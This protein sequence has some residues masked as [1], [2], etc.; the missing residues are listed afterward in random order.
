MQNKWPTVYLSIADF[1]LR[2][3]FQPSAELVYNQRLYQ[4]IMLQLQGFISTRHNY[5]VDYQINIVHNSTLMLDQS[6]QQVLAPIY[7]LLNSRIL[8]ISY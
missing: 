8:E 2:I 4:A 3:V 5:K 7:R 1:S 6:K